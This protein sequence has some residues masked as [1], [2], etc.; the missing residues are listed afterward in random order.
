MVTNTPTTRQQRDRAKAKLFVR[1]RLHALALM[2]LVA[3]L[4]APP[5]AAQDCR[6]GHGTFNHSPMAGSYAGIDGNFL[7][8][9][10]L[11]TAADLHWFDAD[12]DYHMLRYTAVDVLSGGGWVGKKLPGQSDIGPWDTDVIGYKPA[13]PGAIQVIFVR[14]DADEVFIVRHARMQ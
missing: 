4:A 9:I 14:P 11:C 3:H 6:S 1:L 13:E 2:L 8:V 10:H 12:G 5:A 7:L